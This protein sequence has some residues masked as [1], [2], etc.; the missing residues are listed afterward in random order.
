M[1][2]RPGRTVLTLLGITLGVA[3]SVAIALTLR[4]TR[5][6]HREMFEAVGGRASLEVVAEGLGGFPASLADELGRVEGVRAAVPVIHTP[7]L[8]VGARGAVP[9]LALGVDPARD[10]AARDYALRRG[11][12]LGDGPGA[13]L[14]AGFAEANGLDVGARAELLTVGGQA[15][16]RVAGLL[17]P[18]GA[19]AFNGG[20]VA[21]L[22]LPAAQRLFRLAG[23][24]N[25]V[26]LV[27]AE[28]AD[29]DEVEAAV[30]GRLP[31]GLTVQVPSARAVSGRHL[32]ASSELGLATLG[33]VSVV[34]GAFVILNAFLMSLGER[35]RHLA[36]LRAL[37]ATRSQVARLLLREAALLGGAGAALGVGLGWAL[38]LG[39]RQVMGQVMTLTLPAPAWSWGPALIGL[40]LGPGIALAAA[41]LPARRAGRRAPL[42]DLLQRRDAPSGPLPAW[43]GYLGLA[44]V[45]L[46]LLLVRALTWGWIPPAVAIPCIPPAMALYL[47]GC[48]LVLPLILRPLLR[49]AR[50]V[51]RPVLGVEGSLALRLLERRPVRTALTAGVLLVAVLFALGFGQAFENQLRHINTWLAQVAD[52]G[53]FFIRGAWPDATSAVTTAPLPEAL[54]EEIQN[55][56]SRVARVDRY[57]YIPTQ[58]CGQ[59]VVVL[60]YTFGRDRPPPLPLVAGDPEA[61]RAG[62]RRGETV[63]GTLLAQRLG[64]A[65]GDSLVLQTR[66]GPRP[67]RVAGLATEYTA[68]GMALYLEWDVA[69][70]LFDTRGAHALTITAQPGQADALR[71]VLRA[72][73][74]GRHYLFE[75]NAEMRSHFD[76]QT[77]DFRALIWAL[78]ALV[79]VVA[80]LGVVNTLTMNVLE[81]TRELGAL[82]AIGMRRGQVARTVLAQAL[83]LGLVSLAPGTAA[84]L[85]LAYLMHVS[86]YPIMGQVVPFRLDPVLAAG[87]FVVALA[88]AA[89]AGYVPARRAAR[90]RP[91]E[92]LQYE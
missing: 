35:R 31:A 23:Q 46:V 15:P 9:V 49:L 26:Q 81:Q 74:A 90:L 39:L 67:L 18:R 89:A 33:T 58:A 53:D 57:R 44:L 7:A 28:G 10:G 91:V 60:A 21:F 82:R 76:R 71:P 13:L 70:Q 50:A 56:D 73:C 85:G 4:T 79:F 42:D 37:G 75:S 29:P 68:G 77:R 17:E 87:C 84:G 80:A 43:P 64:L 6:A 14:E 30:R 62:L 24:V 83:G 40:A 59:P 52:G 41:Y 16:V 3:A 25:C 19:A 69:R 45:A 54:P 32:I 61:V 92:A 8:L 65:A 55:L 20:A 27:L 47:V 36:I 34:A 38:S 63:V 88:V 51:V 48:A 86:T 66:H 12:P 72:F 5:R 1:Q 78:V 2:R 22:P 11:R